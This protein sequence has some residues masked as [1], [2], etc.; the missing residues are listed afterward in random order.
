MKLV[1]ERYNEM[2]RAME[3]EKKAKLEQLYDQ[4]VSFQ[5]STDSAKETMETMTKEIEEAEELAFLLVSVTLQPSLSNELLRRNCVTSGVF[6]F[7]PQSY[8]DI[9]MR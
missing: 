3:E 6:F 5:E 2:S 8:K 7:P 4:I 9:D 1:M